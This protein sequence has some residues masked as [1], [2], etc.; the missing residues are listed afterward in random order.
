MRIAELKV[1]IPRWPTA[2]IADIDGLDGPDEEWTGSWFATNIDGEPDKVET[3]VADYG[4][5]LGRYLAKLHNAAP[6]LIAAIAAAEALADAVA[7][8][9]ERRTFAAGDVVSDRMRAF[10]QALADMETT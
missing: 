3:D 9:G 2:W 7:D 1:E 5:A 4:V 8:Y 6:A 10:R